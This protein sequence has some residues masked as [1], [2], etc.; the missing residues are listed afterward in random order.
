MLDEQFLRGLNVHYAAHSMYLYFL[1]L[2]FNKYWD[3]YQF[4]NV[5]DPRQLLIGNVTLFAL[6]LFC[7]IIPLLDVCSNYALNI[8][9]QLKLRI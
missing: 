7:F 2:S 1:K 4:V 6:K 8:F 9:K 5:K 3:I